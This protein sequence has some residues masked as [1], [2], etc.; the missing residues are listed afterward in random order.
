ML[1]S[2][3][4]GAATILVLGLRYQKIAGILRIQGLQAIDTGHGR[5]LVYFFN[6]L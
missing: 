2:Q 1:E 3:N 4:P 5:I 6:Q